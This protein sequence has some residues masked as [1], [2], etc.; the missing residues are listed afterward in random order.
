MSKPRYVEVT[1]PDEILAL[2]NSSCEL[3]QPFT[4][5]YRYGMRLYGDADELRAWR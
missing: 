1:L 3:D 4:Y 5:R 2:E